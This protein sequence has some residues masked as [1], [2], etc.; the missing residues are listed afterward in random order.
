[1]ARFDL[2]RLRQGDRLIVDVQSDHASTM[3]RTRVVVPLI[4]VD[5]LD[6]LIAVLNP[7]VECNGNNYAF[8]A[9]A[10]AT[11]S[12]SELGDFVASLAPLYDELARALDILLTGF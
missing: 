8:A 12:K 11:L 6:N 10:I 7:I 5:E 2:Y 4:P 9:Q 1:L 3:L